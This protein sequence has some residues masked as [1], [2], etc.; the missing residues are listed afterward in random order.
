M[1]TSPKYKNDHSEMRPPRCENGLWIGNRLWIAV[2]WDINRILRA[3]G[4]ILPFSMTLAKKRSR[5]AFLL[6]PVFWKS[7][8]PGSH[9]VLADRGEFLIG[10]QEQFF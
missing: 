9:F 10:L 8:R 7:P 2:V 5:M 1:T 6:A 3:K 4:D